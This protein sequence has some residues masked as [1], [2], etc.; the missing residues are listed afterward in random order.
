VHVEYGMITGIAESQL[1]LLNWGKVK[2]ATTADFLIRL[3][4]HKQA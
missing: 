4:P 2:G 3:L 1:G